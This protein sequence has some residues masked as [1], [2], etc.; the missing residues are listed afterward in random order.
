MFIRARHLLAKVS[1][2]TITFDIHEIYGQSST[3]YLESS[4]D[5]VGQTLR[6]VI[7]GNKTVDDNRN[8]M[9]VGLSKRLCIGE[10]YNFP[11]Y[12]SASESL[13]EKFS[14]QIRELTLLLINNLSEN[15]ILG[16][17]LDLHNLINNLL[18]CLL[19]YLL[20][21]LSAMRNTNTSP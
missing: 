4:F 5:R 18:S 11:V 20:A 17:G 1:V 10:L 21:T 13:A 15:L 9:L 6:D 3:S 19:R 2:L 7:L 8:V 16:A 14:E 12:N